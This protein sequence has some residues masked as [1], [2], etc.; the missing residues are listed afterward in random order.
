MRVEILCPTGIGNGTEVFVDGKQMTCV[1]GLTLTI[2]VD[3]VARLELRTI[4]VDPADQP[5]LKTLE[6]G[7][8]ELR[9]ETLVFTGEFPSMERK[10]Q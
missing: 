4:M 2:D 5:M 9:K 1:T 7:E 10:E 8:R 6:N 3:E